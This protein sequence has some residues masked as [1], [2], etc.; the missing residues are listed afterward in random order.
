M[1]GKNRSQAGF[2]GA[3]VGLLKNKTGFT[4]GSKAGLAKRRKTDLIYDLIYIQQI[5]GHYFRF[6]YVH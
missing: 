2:G 1:H 3:Y 5:P 4:G 6:D